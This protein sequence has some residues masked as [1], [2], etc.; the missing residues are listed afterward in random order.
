[1]I[2]KEQ[3]IQLNEEQQA[4]YEQSYIYQKN[5]RFNT[6]NIMNPNYIGKQYSKVL[7]IYRDRIYYFK[8]QLEMQEAFE[9]PLNLLEKHGIPRD[10]HRETFKVQIGVIGFSKVGKSV[11]AKELESNLDLVRI[12]VSNLIRGV[13]QNSHNKQN[14]TIIKEYLYRGE[15]IPDE[16]VL[17]LIK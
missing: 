12:K 1:M 8:N 15:Q 11:L 10:T 13:L 2:E 5:V 6:Q 9:R 3:C 4:Q 17:R 14:Q 16:L 7:G